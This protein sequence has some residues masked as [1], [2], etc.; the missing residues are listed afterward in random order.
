MEE[1]L[2]RVMSFAQLKF[3]GD[4]MDGTIGQFMQSCS[5]RVTAIS[6]HT[7]FFSLELNRLDDAVLEE[8]LKDPA[9]AQ[10]GPLPARPPCVPPAPAFRRGGEAAARQI[11]HRGPGVEPPVRR[12]GRRHAG[13]VRARRRSPSA[14]C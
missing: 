3:S 2:G 11:R 12:D 7:I 14:M 1:V 9:L 4:S 8:G 5:E 13:A 6:A 10:M